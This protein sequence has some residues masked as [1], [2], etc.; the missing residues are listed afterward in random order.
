LRNADISGACLDD[1]NT[2]RWK[3]SGVKCTHLIQRGEKVACEKAEFAQKQI[4]FESLAEIIVDLPLGDLSYHF[5][6]MLGVSIGEKYGD[7]WRNVMLQGIE[8]LDDQR[9][10][11]QYLLFEHVEDIKQLLAELQEE[12]RANSDEIRK[13]QTEIANEDGEMVGYRSKLPTSLSSYTFRPE[14]I[15]T[16]LNRRFTA[17][18]P[19]LQRLTKM[20]VQALGQPLPA[21]NGDK[22]AIEEKPE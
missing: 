20:V 11:A 8:A 7:A 19:A 17:M 21:E 16:R 15:E 1:A 6:E 22:P 2:A 18:A 4:H 9:T 5:Y 3:I 12:F 13:M 10:R 14:E